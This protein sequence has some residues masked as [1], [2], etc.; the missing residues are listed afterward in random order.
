[1]SFTEELRIP[2]PR[3]VLRFESAGVKTDN[4]M[5][6]SVLVAD[7]LAI[8]SLGESGTRRVPHAQQVAVACKSLEGHRCPGNEL[9]SYKGALI[10]RLDTDFLRPEFHGS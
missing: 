1:M 3:T 7:G 10:L 6:G 8:L 4:M 5:P 2:T 9:G